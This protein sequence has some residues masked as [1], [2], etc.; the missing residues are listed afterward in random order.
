MEVK[1]AILKRRSIRKYLD[2]EIDDSIV[3]EL[4]I[5]AMAAPSA[6]NKTPWEFYV[7]KNKQILEKLE[8]TAYFRTLKSPLKIV[9]CGNKDLFM[10]PDDTMWVQ[11]L[12]AAIENILLTVT[13]LGLGAC[14][15]G[16]YPREVRMNRTIETLNLPKTIIPM[17]IVCI[18]YPDEEKEERTQYD[19]NKIHY[20][21]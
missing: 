18:G 11:D 12:S 9:V 19:K 20:I 2:K 7:V 3:E 16:V 8:D 14:W 21:Y 6:C 5:S 13:D 15:C 1:S 4:L 10:T 17:G